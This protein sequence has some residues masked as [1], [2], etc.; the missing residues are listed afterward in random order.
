MVILTYSSNLDP[1]TKFVNIHWVLSEL[2]YRRV[3]TQSRKF[4]FI[5]CRLFHAKKPDF[6]RS[7]FARD[8]KGGRGA[9]GRL[10]I[11]RPVQA[12]NFALFKTA[13]L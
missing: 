3:Q 6:I 11:W 12:N 5:L 4:V 9:P 2:K 13:I 8:L 7:V 1:H 10:K